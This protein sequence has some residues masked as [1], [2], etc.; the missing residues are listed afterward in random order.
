[1]SLLTF[2]DFM[3]IETEA[4]TRGP[5]STP[6]GVE[7]CIRHSLEDIHMTSSYGAMWENLDL[8]LEAHAGMLPVLG[9]FYGDIYRA[10]TWRIEGMEYLDSVLSDE[11]L[12]VP[13]VPDMVGSLGAALIGR[14]PVIGNEK[15]W[16]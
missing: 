15:C 16:N 7:P 10:R 3:N 11:S 12:M 14:N 9:K 1:M 4:G 2:Q 6:T 8:D 5:G 13:P